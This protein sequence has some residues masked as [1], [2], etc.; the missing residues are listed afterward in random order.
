M[1]FVID[2]SVAVKWFNAEE[3]SDK[4]AEVKDAYVRGDLELAAPS[5]IIYEVGNSIWKNPQL[6]DKDA[7]DAIISVLRLGMQL[8]PPN[9]ERVGR[10]M[11][12]GRQR[13]ITFYDAAY[14]QS[15]EELKVAL[16]SA[17]EHQTAAAKG[18]VQV[19]RLREAK[20]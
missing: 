16:L 13:S 10:A 9:V 1:R 11:K 7:G 4:A 2:A 6:A 20:L 15:A 5:H 17:D 3:L 14:V 12:I 18:I 19:V 8:L